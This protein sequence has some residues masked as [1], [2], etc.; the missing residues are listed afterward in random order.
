MR[1]LVLFVLIAITTSSSAGEK[2]KFPFKPADKV[3]WCGSSSTKIG[4]WPRTME[5][6]LRTRHPELKL[7]FQRMTTGGGTFDTGLKNLDQWMGEFKPTLLF[8]NYGGNDAGGGAAGL[9]KFKDNIDACVKKVEGVGA[10]VWFMPPQAADTRKSG[11]EPAARRQLYAETL[12]AYCKEK[13]WP[14]VDTFHPLAALQKG[15]Q[16]KDEAYTILNDKIHLTAPAYIAWAYYLYDGLNP[17]AAVSTATIGADGKVLDAKGCDIDDV[18][19]QKDG[20]SFVRRDRILPLLPPA[21][22]PPSDLVPLEKHSQYRLAVPGLTAGNY[23]IAWEGKT[24]GSA[25]A[26]D[27]AKGVNLNSLVL[28]SGQDAPW[29]SV[30]EPIWLNKDLSTIGKTSWK[31]TVQKR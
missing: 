3:A 13:G 28:Q 27:L 15:G 29:N 4:V 7:E 18:Q 8:F 14:I 31:F 21:K 22:L 6:L 5:F 20:V 10:R 17:P 2:S 11:E 16:A 19:V 30:I 12:L 23:E 9:P 25:S 1:P 24:F 26:A